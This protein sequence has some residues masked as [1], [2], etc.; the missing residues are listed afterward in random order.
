MLMREFNDSFS[1]ME[2]SP[3]T[4]PSPPS[5]LQPPD[6]PPQP[7]FLLSYDP[8]TS[9]SDPVMHIKKE[10]PSKK[11]FGMMPEA[12]AIRQVWSLPIIYYKDIDLHLFFFTISC[13]LLTFKEIFGKTNTACVLI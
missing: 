9:T 11:L 7:T 10:E 2:I 3:E 5:P 8:I 4:A 12:S 1:T 6:L 13:F